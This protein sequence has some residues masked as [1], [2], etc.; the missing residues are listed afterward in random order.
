MANFIRKALATKRESKHVEF[1]QTFNPSLPGEWCELIKDIV[2]IANSGG[3]IIVFGYLVEDRL[4][5]GGTA[6]EVFSVL[7]EPH[8]VA[9]FSLV[10]RDIFF[11]LCD[12]L[13]KRVLNKTAIGF[14]RQ[15]A[16]PRVEDS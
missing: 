9:A 4:N 5:Y 15:V 1:K 2:A 12:C 3:G 10:Y 11:E 6:G 14:V 16:L 7:V 13:L 8:A